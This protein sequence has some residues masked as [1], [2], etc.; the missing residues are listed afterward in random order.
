MRDRGSLRAVVPFVEVVFPCEIAVAYATAK[1]Q[2]TGDKEHLISGDLA[3]A[4]EGGEWAERS[5]EG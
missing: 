1:E 3:G 5:G 4:K 2:Q